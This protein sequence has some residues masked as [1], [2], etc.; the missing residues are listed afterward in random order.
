VTC[1][2]PSVA[3]SVVWIVPYE[4]DQQQQQRHRNLNNLVLEKTIT[5]CMARLLSAHARIAFLESFEREEAIA[6]AEV[7]T[8]R[9]RNQE[10]DAQVRQFNST[11]FLRTR[12]C[13]VQANIGGGSGADVCAAVA[14]AADR[15]AAEL[16][17]MHAVCSD[18]SKLI[19]QE[20]RY[21]LAAAAETIHKLQR[22]HAA[23]LHKISLQDAKIEQATC[24]LQQQ[25]QHDIH[26]Q[27]LRELEYKR[28]IS[29]LI[30]RLSSA[31]LS[32]TS[33]TRTS[34][35]ALAASDKEVCVL[36]SALAEETG[37]HR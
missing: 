34:D 17:A 19:Q 2:S 11:S 26:Q 31:A 24:Q 36:K 4:S 3:G 8:L 22:D 25:K 14:A 12:S 32:L 30:N 6:R 28:Q 9:A 10:L 7:S 15:H 21:V 18:S 16:A 37:D 20:F 27:Q 1:A 35:E 23:A 13:G 33:A 5:D 29:D